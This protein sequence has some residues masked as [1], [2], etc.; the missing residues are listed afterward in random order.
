MNLVATHYMSSVMMI[1]SGQ[2]V[3]SRVSLHILVMV[4]IAWNLGRGG[5]K[6]VPGTRYGTQWKTP[7]KSTVTEPYHAVEKRHNLMGCR[8]V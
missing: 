7:Q 6:K 3:I 1:F 4:R 5:T 2:S 8:P